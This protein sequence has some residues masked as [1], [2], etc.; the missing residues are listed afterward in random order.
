MTAVRNV[1]LPAG[2]VLMSTPGGMIFLVW[3]AWRQHR[4]L[5]SLQ[6][7]T[8][9]QLNRSESLPSAVAVTGRTASVDRDLLRAPRSETEC[10]WYQI[11]YARRP[12][13]DE[14]VER[15]VDFHPG[16][17]LV[18][19]T[20][21]TGTVFL[22]PWLART[23]LEGS[24]IATMPAS[25]RDGDVDWQEVTIRPDLPVTAIGRP[26]YAAAVG[27]LTTVI[28]EKGP[29]R[30][31]DSS[32]PMGS[33]HRP[34]GSQDGVVL[35]AGG[36][37]PYGVVRLPLEQVRESRARSLRWTSRLLL[38]LPALGIALILLTWAVE[39]LSR[40]TPLF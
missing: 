14:R 37:S 23:T 31:P 9:D 35:D 25:G 7:P 30:L 6:S 36:R 24:A 26:K 8:C 27:P 18:P 22:T 33:H 1:L 4:Q 34:S 38:V 32:F 2:L 29:W 11:E 3:G 28:V 16:A 13:N 12:Y 19:V 15:W 10:V 20:D 21:G 39:W 17:E 5:R 40:N